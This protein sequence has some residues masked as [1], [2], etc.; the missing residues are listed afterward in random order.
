MALRQEEAIPEHHTVLHH[1]RK[2]LNLSV[3][4][5]RDP[6][7]GDHYRR[8]IEGRP[9]TP[10]GFRDWESGDSEPKFSIVARMAEIYDPMLEAAGSDFRI[11]QA[12]SWFVTPDGQPYIRWFTET[13]PDLQLV[14]ST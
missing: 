8:G 14:D 4:A 10:A 11:S 7:V 1:V 12:T 9:I 3:D 13:H 6:F 5:M 2:I